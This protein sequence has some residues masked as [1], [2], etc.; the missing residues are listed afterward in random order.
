VTVR[1]PEFKST[2]FEDDTRYVRDASTGLVWHRVWHRV[3]FADTD[4]T[5]VVYHA[6]YFRFFEMGRSTLLRDA[7]FPLRQVEGDGYVYPIF[8]VGVD[9]FRPMDYDAP[10]WVHTRFRDLHGV[11]VDFDYLITHAE[12]GLVLCTGFTRHCAVNRKGRPVAVD[13]VTVGIFRQFPT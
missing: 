6:N 12:T 10:I 1:A 2:P 8:Q 13:P 7:G 9:Y 4:R 3:L 11:R 5:G